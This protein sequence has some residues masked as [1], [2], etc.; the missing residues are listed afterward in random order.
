MLIYGSSLYNTWIKINVYY[1]TMTE[2]EY[3]VKYYPMTPL[4]IL[5]FENKGYDTHQPFFIFL[6]LNYSLSH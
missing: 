4:Q 2:N 3:E 6:L 5:K 1:F